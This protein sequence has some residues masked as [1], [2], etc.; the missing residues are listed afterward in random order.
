MIQPYTRVILFIAMFIV[1]MVGVAQENTPSIDSLQTGDAFTSAG[2]VAINLKLGAITTIDASQFNSGNINDPFQLVQGKVAG[3]L[4]AK[5]GNDPNE[6]FSVRIRG[7][8]SVYL[9]NSPL[10]IVD[11]MPYPSLLSVD[12]MDISSITVIKN[13]ATCAQFG[14]NSQSGVVLIETKNGVE[15]GLFVRNYTALESPDLSNGPMTAD[16]YMTAGGIDLGGRTQWNE[17]ITRT[18]LSNVTHVSY[19]DSK[20]TTSYYAAL[21]YRNINGVLEESGFDNFNG[22]GRISQGLVNGRL[23]FSGDVSFSARRNDFSFPEAFKYTETFYPTSP[24]MLGSDYAQYQVFDQYNPAAMIRQ[25]IN[26]GTTSIIRGGLQGSFDLTSD[27]KLSAGFM[28]ENQQN[29]NRQ[30]WSRS[31]VWMGQFNTGYRRE[32]FH[33][34]KSNFGYSTLAW[35]RTAGE[36]SFDVSAGLAFQNLNFLERNLTAYGFS[37][38]D[39]GK[40]EIDNFESFDGGVYRLIHNAKTNLGINSYRGS[41]SWTH[42]DRLMMTVNAATETYSD[43]TTGTT[44]GA[45]LGFDFAANKKLGNIRQLKPI[46]SWGRSAGAM[47]FFQNYNPRNI[48]QSWASLSG[49]DVTTEKR[50]EIDGGVDW[51]LNRIGGSLHIFSASTSDVIVQKFLANP[52]GTVTIDMVNEAGIRNSG[53]EIDLNATVI[54][55]KNLVV[56]TSFNLA[57]IRNAFRT[58]TDLEGY[59]ALEYILFQGAGNLFALENNKP[60]GQIR[61]FSLREIDNLFRFRDIDRD[62]NFSYNSNDITTFGKPLPSAFF[63]W[64]TQISSGRW[65]TS[66]VFRGAMG[67][68]LYNT[69]R[70]AYESP[71]FVPLYNAP[72]SI[73]EAPLRDLQDVTYSSD[74]YMEKASYFTLDNL[75]VT[76][77][78]IRPGQRAFSCSVQIAVQNA[79]MLT[80][81]DGSSP[82]PRLDYYGIAYAAGFDSQYTY[83]DSRTFLVGIQF[84]N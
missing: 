80:G 48:I 42:A 5:A 82:E 84:H 46:I 38:D 47:P 41:F 76:Y 52:N 24:V 68:K 22:R 15:H 66:A 75:A 49:Y 73:L 67:H 17:E 9:S 64:T 28:A 31:S 69:N 51:S 78:F 65:R 33:Q 20:G 43:H 62:G 77:E 36:S 83:A 45:A 29:Q 1:S 35:S 25:N 61:G 57:T 11:G 13:A 10:I 16:Q 12:P 63:G 55:R 23:R 21:N 79:F 74:Y 30:Y 58:D 19:G 44:F 60:I 39:E 34:L 37:T 18:A 72:P 4:I 40:A 50:A 70:R 6:P 54:D 53:I 7:M 56:S 59:Q 71:F 32:F 3:L 27:L 14:I 2:P 81:Y 8:N 26:D